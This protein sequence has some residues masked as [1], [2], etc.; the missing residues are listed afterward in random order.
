MIKLDGCNPTFVTA[1]DAILA[2]DLATTGGANYCMIW[3]TFA[4]RGLGVGASSGGNTG[5]PGIQDQTESF[6]QPTPG[7]TPATGSACTLGAD[8]FD[9]N[10]M[11]RIYPNP[12]NGFIN[13]RINNYVGK[14]NFQV[15]DINGRIVSE[16][17]NQDFNVEKALDL[18]SLQSG[19]YVIKIIGDN[20][21]FTEKIIKN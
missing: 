2:A 7:S 14:V 8:Y 16:Y 12:T 9:N 18:N 15:I 3:Q 6:A 17:K 10:D 1:R 5:V 21:N 20:L 13:I 19:V 11:L 4:R